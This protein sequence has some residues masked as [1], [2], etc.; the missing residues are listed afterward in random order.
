MLVMICSR[1]WSQSCALPILIAV[2]ITGFVK[3][4]GDT[5][6]KEL[7]Y[8]NEAANAIR[9]AQIFRDVPYCKIPEV[10]KDLSTH[11]LLVMEYEI[12][13]ASCREGV[14]VDVRFVSCLK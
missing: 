4:F 1:D 6:I 2:N 14:D 9:F 7:N 10:Y 5:M 3:E 12:G 8:Q 11:K 13:R